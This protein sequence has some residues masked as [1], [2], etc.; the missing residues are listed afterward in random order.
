MI[1]TID[2]PAGAGKSTVARE[3][4][5]RLGYLFLDTGAM[6]RAATYAVMQT[7]DLQNQKS[8]LAVTRGIQIDLGDGVVFVDGDDVT[9]PIR[10]AEVTENIH[11][12][13]DDSSVRAVLVDRQRAIANGQ[14]VVTEGRD[15][16]TVAFPE[17]ECKIFLTASPQERARRRQAERAA[18][19]EEVSVDDIR[20]A[21][22]MRDERDKSRLVGA[23]KKAGDAVEVVTD[24]M[25]IEDVIASLEALVQKK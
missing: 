23:L 3:L 15:Q 12:L 18:R 14:S 16:G 25:T 20:A 1:V 19:G 10:T 17:A 2:G 8:R 11:Y 24:G 7:G 13:A 21:Q 6:Y 4:A 9:G 5:A 22:E